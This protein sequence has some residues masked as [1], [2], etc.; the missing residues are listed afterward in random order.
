MTSC[1]NDDEPG[2]PTGYIRCNFEGEML[3]VDNKNPYTAG[4]YKYPYSI[5]R[6]MH[7]QVSGYSFFSEY[8]AS[9]VSGAPRKVL[10]LL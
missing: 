10:A 1:S 5:A 3:Q 4:S 9:N 7:M 6:A 8:Y 2:N